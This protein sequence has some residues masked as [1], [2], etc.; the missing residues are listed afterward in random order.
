MMKALD[1]IQMEGTD[2]RTLMKRIVERVQVLMATHYGTISKE[3]KLKERAVQL[4]STLRK[5]I[6]DIMKKI[7]EILEKDPTDKDASNYVTILNG[8]TVELQRLNLDP[9][10]S[11]HGSRPKIGSQRP[12]VWVGGTKMG[13]MGRGP[14]IFGDFFFYDDGFF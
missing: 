10:F 3:E 11:N 4:R 2:E 7:L 6:T 9:G 12:L 14:K 1:E 5:R 8:E 13:R